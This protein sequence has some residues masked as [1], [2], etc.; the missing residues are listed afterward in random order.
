MQGGAGRLDI[1]E[2]FPTGSMKRNRFALP[3]VTVQKEADTW[4]SAYAAAH[5]DFFLR[6]FCKFTDSKLFP[7]KTRWFQFVLIV[8]IKKGFNLNATSEAPPNVMFCF[9]E[10]LKMLHICNNCTGNEYQRGPRQ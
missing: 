10:D 9:E 3:V 7:M 1:Y 6:R 5:C 2:A 4:R 8:V